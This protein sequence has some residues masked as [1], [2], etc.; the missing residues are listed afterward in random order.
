MSQ[1]TIDAL[2]PTA[3]AVAYHIQE[4]HTHRR[5]ANHMQFGGP[6]GWDGSRYVVAAF[7]E[8]GV[9]D[10]RL[11]G[12][13]EV[14]I[15][16]IDV[17]DVKPEDVYV[18]PIEH[19]GTPRVVRAQVLANRNTTMD[20]VP[21]AMKYRDLQAQTMADT[22]AKEVGA[23]LAVGLRQQ[24]GYGSE[25]AQIS[26]ETEVTLN[27]EASVKAAW[28]RAMTAHKEHEIESSR[29]IVIRALH[30][31]TL[32]RVETVGPARQIIKAKGALAFGVRI[33]APGSWV[34][35]WDNMADFIA[36]L[37]GI[38]T[39]TGGQWRDLYRA[40]PVP[41]EKLA[42]F[43]Q[44]VYAESVKVREFE[45]ASNVRVDIRS[46]PL[47]DETKLQDALRLVALQG[48]TP[49]LRQLAEAAIA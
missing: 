27:M 4:W 7:A 40:Y 30:E 22:V 18:G 19:I 9:I 39:K 37:Q 48:P 45:E 17:T 8:P 3:A 11:R 47:N 21:W 13:A 41:I 6:E 46:E 2:W 33:H 49:E 29:D 1:E 35:Q 38:E 12:G 14:R 16:G 42:P 26:G 28:E 32:E 43:R 5:G 15:F 23:S 36:A 31:A 20:D 34:F 24:V 44:T 25:V 10:Y